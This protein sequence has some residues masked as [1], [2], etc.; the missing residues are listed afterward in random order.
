MYLATRDLDE[1]MDIYTA[2]WKKGLKSTYYLHMKPRHT[3]EQSTTKVNKAEK[4][5]KKGFAAVASSRK[6]GEEILTADAISP[7]T[8]THEPVPSPLSDME[9]ATISRHNFVEAS[10]SHAEGLI[11]ETADEAAHK[12]TPV[13]KGFASVSASATATTPTPVSVTSAAPA[14]VTAAQTPHAS[15]GKGFASVTAS[16]P[17]VK[18][19]TEVYSGTFKPTASAVPAPTVKPVL[20]PEQVQEMMSNFGKKPA[21]QTHNH[22]VSGPSDPGTENI[23]IGCE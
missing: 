2:A 21:Q 1:T 13:G 20:T 12:A 4:M 19:N 18:I 16:A 23:C 22:T 9:I 15:H 10:V 7:V 11:M 3:A 17:V 8:R 5:G 6:D 14:P